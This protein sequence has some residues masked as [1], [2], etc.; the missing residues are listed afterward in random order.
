MIQIKTKNYP[1]AT[2]E[3]DWPIESPLINAHFR[4]EDKPEKTVTVQY[5]D[6]LPIG[7]CLQHLGTKFNITINNQRQHELSQYLLEK[8][9]QDLTKVVLSPMPGSVVSIAVNVGD[10]V[11]II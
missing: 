7:F 6:P 5:I 8:P 1:A 4:V 2:I 9:K 3:A 10:I 11:S